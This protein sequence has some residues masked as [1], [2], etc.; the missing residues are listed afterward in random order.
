MFIG[1]ALSLAKSLLGFAQKRSSDQVERFRIETGLNETEIKANVELGAQAASVIKAG[2]QFKV[3]WVPWS[4]AAIPMAA[5]FGWGVLDTAIYNG[6]ILPDVG[7]LPDQ[8][9]RYGDAVWNSIFYSGAAVGSVQ[10]ISRTISN[11]LT[12]RIR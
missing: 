10:A 11:A 9:A 7:K 6:S 1:F 3:F 2:M 8:L 5:W 12:R 4:M